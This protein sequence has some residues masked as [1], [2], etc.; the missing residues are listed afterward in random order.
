LIQYTI[1]NI[2]KKTI[3]YMVKSV[4]TQITCAV[5]GFQ[6][7]EQCSPHAYNC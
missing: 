5:T 3:H 4:V 2:N 6:Q 1:D 7:N